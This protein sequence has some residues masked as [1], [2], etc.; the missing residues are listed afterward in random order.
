M[1]TMTGGEIL[2]RLLKHEGV[3]V[4]YGVCGGRLAS[5]MA[6]I[7]HEPSIDY[8]GTRHEA[9]AAHM[10]C[11]TYHSTGKVGVCMGEIGAAANLIPGVATAYGMSIPMLV[12]TSNNPSTLTYPFEEMMMDIDNESLFRPVTKWNAVVRDINR[13]PSLVR[14][15]FREALSGRP[16]PVHL[17]IPFDILFQSVDIDESLLDIMPAQYR[18]MDRP[19]GDAQKIDEAAELLANAQRPVLLAGGGVVASGATAEF[20]QLAKLL[21]APATA[22]QMG[23]GVVSSDDPNFIGTSGII[24]GHAIPQALTEADVVLL[25]GCR[26]SS[27][28]WDGNGPLVKGWPYQ[29]VIQIDIHPS[30]IGNKT[31]VT[32]GIQ[33]DAKAI[34]TDL[35]SAL[36][37]RMSPVSGRPWTRT[38]VETYRRYREELERLADDW[39]NNGREAMHPATLAREVGQFISEHA[40]DAFVVLDGGAPYFWTNDFTPVFEP[41]TRFFEAGTGIL[42]F[43]TPYAHAIKKLHP[44]R[45]VFNITGDGSFGF[46]MH[47]LDTAKRYGLSVI[48]IIHDNGS[49]GIIKAG[50]KGMYGIELGVDLSE[51]NYAEIAKG[52]GCYGERISDP[53]E[54]QPAIQRAMESG[55]PAVLDVEVRFAPHLTSKIFGEMGF[56]G[57]K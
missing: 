15:A 19:R 42:G 45:P 41:R 11:A 17:D 7:Y 14:R 33:G 30:V 12:I 39:E 35:L 2:V 50:Q 43:G 28:L 55:L 18:V 22:T 24:G 29:K 23:A 13:M 51:S 21:D 31:H 36:E 27:W 1:T 3:P 53:K 20:R 6:A 44:D 25:V 32:V 34:L 57:V 56:I 38:V 47:E 54:I 16:G 26:L 4:V 46:A 52:Y 48:H 49:W 8:V 5:F 37:E 10:A 40:R 9:N